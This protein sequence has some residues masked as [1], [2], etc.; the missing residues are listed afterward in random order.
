MKKL[1]F[2][3][4]F[5]VSIL[6]FSQ[7]SDEEFAAVLDHQIETLQLTGEKKEA[8]V[9]I[10]NKY[11]EQFKST[12]ESEGSRLTKMKALKTI[13][14]NKNEELK[15]LLSESEFESFKEMQ[16]ENRSKLKERY[17]QRKNS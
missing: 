1:M 12:R 16:K 9:E 6:G 13:Q 5:C 14:D 11:F 8:F 7:E 3:L 17:K 4:M 10:S 15:Q 2:A